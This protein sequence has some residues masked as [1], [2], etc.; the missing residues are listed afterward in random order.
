MV[1]A[2][3]MTAYNHAFTIAFEPPGSTDPNEEE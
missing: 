2:G 3:E 1:E